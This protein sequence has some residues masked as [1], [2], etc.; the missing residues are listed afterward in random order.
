MLDQRGQ[1][2]RAAIGFAGCPSR[3][4]IVRSTRSAPGST[5]GPASGT[6]RSEWRAKASISKSR[7]NDEKGWRA[8]FYTTG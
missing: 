6:S 5:R 7:E 1:L 8:T 3:H 4:T 2:M